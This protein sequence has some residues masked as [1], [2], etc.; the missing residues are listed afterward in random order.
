MTVQ[1]NKVYRQLYF[2][3]TFLLSALILFASTAGTTRAEN[4]ANLATITGIVWFDL[5]RNGVR[6]QGE[7]LMS[8]HPVYLEEIGDDLPG[9]MIAR[10]ETDGEGVFTFPNL[11]H[12]S[13]RIYLKDGTSLDVAI[14]H[15]RSA[16]SVELS[17]AGRQ[18]FLPLLNR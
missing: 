3:A 18:I 8:N 2:L 15:E 9:A 11:E 14:S 16:A 10:V 12:G 5:N 6:D 17:F 7:P 4:P 1:N 13:Y